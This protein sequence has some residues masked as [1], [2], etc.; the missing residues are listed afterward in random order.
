MF[1]KEIILNLVSLSN[2]LTPYTKREDRVAYQKTHPRSNVK[3][4]QKS[5]LAVHAANRFI[6][7]SVYTVF[8]K[9]L[10]FVFLLT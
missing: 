3:N 1:K 10:F 8:L 7:E 9:N 6:V 4:T 2:S 5:P